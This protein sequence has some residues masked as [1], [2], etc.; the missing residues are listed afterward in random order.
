[1]RVRHRARRRCAMAGF[2]VAARD[3][4]ASAAVARRSPS[5]RAWRSPPSSSRSSSRS[6]S[7]SA[8]PRAPGRSKAPAWS[9]SA[10]ASGASCRAPSATCCSCSPAC[11]CCS[12]RAP[13]RADGGLQ[14]LSVQRPDG[15][16]GVARRRALRRI[17]AAAT[18]AIASPAR[19]SCEPLLIGLATLWLVSTAAIEIDR[20]RRLASF[21]LAA[22]LVAV[23]RH[24]RCCTLLLAPGFAWPAHRLADAGAGA[25]ACCS[26]AATAAGVLAHPLQAGGCLGL[27][28][29]LRR[30]CARSLRLAAPGWPRAGGARRSTR[31]A[32]LALAL[33]RRAARPGRHRALGRRGERLAVARLARR[34]GGVAAAAHRGRSVARRLAGARGCRAAYA[35]I[36]AAAVLAA[37]LWL[38][39]LVA[40][41][42]SDG[43]AAPLPH[44]PLLN[45]LDVGVGLA[46][47]AIVL[48][49]R[50]GRPGIAGRWLGW[51]WLRRRLRL[52]ERDPGARLPSLRRCAVSRRR[53]A[54]LARGAKP[55]SRCCG[56]L[57]A[58]V[59]MW[60]GGAARARVP[61]VVGAALL[62]AVVLKLLLVD[63]SGT[64]TVT[65]IVSFI[66]V[67]VLMLVIGYVA[68]LPAKEARHV[69]GLSARG[70]RAAV[71]LRREP[72]RAAL[73]ALA[74]DGGRTAAVSLR[75][76][77]RGRAAGAVRR[78]W[79]CRRR[80]MATRRRPDLRDLRIVD[81]AGER[82]P[83]ALLDCRRPRR[84]TERAGARGDALYP[85]PQ[86]PAGSAAGRR[87]STSSS[88]ATGS[89]V[90]RYGRR[91]DRRRATA[92]RESPR[93]ADRSRRARAR[94]TRR[95]SRLL[96]RWS[97]PA[98]FSAA[99]RDRDQ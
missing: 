18:P 96:L 89:R 48:W 11:R 31:S 32:S 6:R 40:N 54:R 55:A 91:H 59:A 19:K 15:R 77:D 83:F 74:A 27:A 72:A 99:L 36:G 7:T 70:V 5:M 13:R 46:L 42:A 71:A 53:L 47:V 66:G 92:P 56:R 30:A 45:P 78:S 28:A 21:A 26:A 73:A 81:A 3:V 8:A 44:L 14:R 63:L 12:A 23:E 76:A 17:A 62:A 97:G 87:R 61:W 16:G 10:F 90:R 50:S 58:L 80:P 37:G 35:Q 86:R 25:V 9:G 67:G 94:P 34:A 75:G 24:R 84:F 95:R 2:Y 29:R 69:C 20:L 79:R 64:G 38:W 52:A 39:T 1:M 43:T 65:R 60:F 22:W 88:T 68:P 49:L 85:L 98:E 51:R 82:V 33:R 93:L 4:D 41:V 57:T